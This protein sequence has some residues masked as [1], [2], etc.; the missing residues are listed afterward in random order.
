MP[1][2]QCEKLSFAYPGTA[3]NAL[4]E[5][6]L[7]IEP[8]EFVALVGANNAGKSSLCYALTGVIPHLYHG[9]MQGI[10]RVDGKDTADCKIADLAR[11]V[12]FVMQKPE[13]QLSGV[14]FTVFEE[15]AF[16]LENQG[17]GR[18]DIRSRVTKTLRM[19]GLENLAQRSPHHLSGGQLQK[20]VLAAALAGDTPVLVLDEP[21]TFLDPLGALQIFE[22]LQQLRTAGK[23]IVLAEQ[24]LENIA[25]FADRVIALDKG[26]AVLDGPSAEVLASPVMREIGLDWTRYTKV[27]ALART[28]HLWPGNAPLPAT[29]S[30]TIRGLENMGTEKTKADLS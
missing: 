27:A 17:M 7:S 14:R 10:I 11:T 12:A 19:L 21:T 20:V 4:N 28:R 22:L 29:L 23:T 3:H 6:S 30:Q 26:T 2:L 25:A 18:D 8:G 16:N 9:N 13:H 24:R 1:I 15:V 5:L